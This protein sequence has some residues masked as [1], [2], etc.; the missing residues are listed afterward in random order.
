RVEGKS[1]AGFERQNRLA[2]RPFAD[3]LGRLASRPILHV[4]Q[5][6]EA[7]R[8]EFLHVHDALLCLS[9][10][11]AQVSTSVR[12]SAAEGRKMRRHSVS[13]SS[14]RTICHM[15]PSS[16]GGCGSP[17]GRSVNAT[18]ANAWPAPLARRAGLR[19]GGNG[20]G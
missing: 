4:V 20:G 8:S 3:I 1:A 14:R 15:S 7:F 6:V 19:E 9:A 10:L 5:L 11:Y 12:Q 2:V 18:E 16:A 17:V 13:P